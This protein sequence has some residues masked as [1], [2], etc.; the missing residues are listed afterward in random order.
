MDAG[1]SLSLLSRSN[2]PEIA[3]IS[4]SKQVSRKRPFDIEMSNRHPKQIKSPS[5]PIPNM[6]VRTPSSPSIHYPRPASTVSS[7][8][9]GSYTDSRRLPMNGDILTPPP[10]SLASASAGRRRTDTVERWQPSYP[11][12]PSLTK[13]ID[14]PALTPQPVLSQP[15]IAASPVLERQDHRRLPQP[16]QMSLMVPPKIPSLLIPANY[17]VTSWGDVE[18]GVSGL[19][20]LGN[21]CWMNSTLQCISATVPFVRF[22]QGILSTH[23]YMLATPNYFILD[24]SWKSAVNMINPLGSKGHLA[25]SFASMVS[26]MWRHEYTYLSPLTFRVSRACFVDTSSSDSS[27][28]ISERV[29]STRTSIWWLKPA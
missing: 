16:Q 9:F 2:L 7:S 6:F 17:T 25:Q 11:S 26:D 3:N 5:P 22:F 12:Q 29:L 28:T 18:L 4:N 24:G 21:T 1:S 10:A 15:P 14:Y 20:N 23:L 19:K 8:T 13:S 27:S